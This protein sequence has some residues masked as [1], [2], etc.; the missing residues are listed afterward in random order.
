MVTHTSDQN[1]G[2][3]FSGQQVCSSD[4]YRELSF[5]SLGLEDIGCHFRKRKLLN[6]HKC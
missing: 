5:S 2:G 6:T 1:G 3:V 4:S